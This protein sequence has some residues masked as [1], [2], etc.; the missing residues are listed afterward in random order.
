MKLA[1]ITV[2][3]SSARINY[4]HLTNGDWQ[5]TTPKEP[6]TYYSV[7][8][9]LGE[10]VAMAMVRKVKGSFLNLRMDPGKK[11]QYL[12]SALQVAE[13]Y[14]SRGIGTTLLNHFIKA[15]KDIYLTVA[16]SNKDAIRLYKRLGFKVIKDTRFDEPHYVMAYYTTPRGYASYGLTK[17]SDEYLRAIFKPYFE[18]DEDLH[19]TLIY[20][21][22][23]QG[24]L[25]GT[26]EYSKLHDV[27]V[28]GLDL[29]GKDKNSL[30]VKLMSHSIQQRFTD[31]LALGYKH[32]FDD[33]IIHCT[34]QYEKGSQNL[35]DMLN[36]EIAKGNL[37]LPTSLKA[38]DEQ[39]DVIIP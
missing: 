5:P 38:T 35:L 36:E 4:S 7:V 2:P 14:Q 27:K 20:D 12:I 19:I 32:N 33:L 18:C 30:V 11:D 31:L 9:E 22:T 21:E 24:N 3:Y 16:L 37:K 26:P 6:T 39:W 15:Y 34:L 17:A 29:L 13:K 25:I 10:C 28:V 1:I 23:V 8:N